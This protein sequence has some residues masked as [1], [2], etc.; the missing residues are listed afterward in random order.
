MWVNVTHR[1]HTQRP[2]QKCE[3]RFCCSGPVDPTSS[4]QRAE[5]H[6]T[7]RLQRL[8]LL[9]ILVLALL[10]TVALACG[11]G[12][13]GTD[14]EAGE[15]TPATRPERIVSYS[16]AA[17]EILYAIGAG[18]QMVGVDR[19]SDFPP[20]TADLQRLDTFFDTTDPEAALALT[21]DLIVTITPGQAEQFR[22]LG[23]TVLL[24]KIPAT[25][26]GVFDD[27]RRLGEATGNA[28]G[29]DA[30]IEDMRTRI[31]A[32]IASIASVDTGPTVFWEIDNTL[33]TVADDSFIGSMLTALKARNIAAGALTAF[34]Q[35]TAEAVIAASPEVI[36]LADEAF[37]ES[38]ETVAARPGWSVIDAVVNGRVMPID[39]DIASRPGPRI[40]EAMETLVSILYPEL[41]E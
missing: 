30:L 40:V 31:D 20:E 14:G 28:E 25:I 32:V 11:G 23:V 5:V 6:V 13:D 1:P 9:P 22:D 12:S 24:L 33:Y 36:V 35:L 34:P 39:P 2:S 3:G 37:G 29:A 27:V 19:Y 4:H 17:T 15:G 21:P 8:G 41:V 10:A 26:E 38:V 18:P 16:P 7:R